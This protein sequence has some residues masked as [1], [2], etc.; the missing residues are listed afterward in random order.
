MEGHKGYVRRHQVRR[1]EVNDPS[2][3]GEMPQVAHTDNVVL[4][5]VLPSSHQSLQSRHRYSITHNL[6]IHIIL[7]VVAV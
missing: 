4:S 7:E 6:I 3:K 1:G 5:Y 2:L